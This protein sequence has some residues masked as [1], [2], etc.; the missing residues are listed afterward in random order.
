MSILFV[1][2]SH[3]DS[4]FVLLVYLAPIPL[5]MAGMGVNVTSGLVA[6]ALGSAGL[7]LMGQP[8]YGIFYLV[9][10]AIPA[11]GLI[12]MA[13]RSRMG[14]DGK[15]EWS[16]EGNLLTALATY[17]CFIFLG[18][19]LATMGQDGGLLALTVNAFNGM[20]DQVNSMLSENGQT[21]TPEMTV[22]IHEYFNFF[23]RITPALAMCAWLFSTIIAMAAAHGLLQYKKWNMRPNF[24]LAKLHIP[25]WVI[26]AAA[27]TGLLAMYG[28]VPYD[29]L[30]L[31]L[32]LVLG[33]P[34][35]FVGLAVVHA[36]AAQTK[37][38][39]VMLTLF[40]IIISIIVHLVLV[41]AVLGAVDQWVDFRKR[42]AGQSSN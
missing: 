17:P 11:G 21:V 22:Q 7:F 31:N 10:D 41:V 26:F 4:G 12:Y 33:I 40:Y 34:F 25:N 20:G 8:S 42:F 37:R 27:I 35:F 38:P 19:Y 30:G 32:A 16:G 15:K 6:I 3:S 23:A 13:M 2:L 28:P 24:L 36:W 5:F 29:Y 18:I 9:A 39:T 1:A 14:L